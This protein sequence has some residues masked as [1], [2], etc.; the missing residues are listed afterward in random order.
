MI[1]FDDEIPNKYQTEWQRLDLEVKDAGKSLLHNDLGF[2]K[3]NKNI[4]KSNIPVMKELS[5]NPVSIK[6]SVI[7]D[8]DDSFIPPRNNFLF[9]GQKDHFWFDQTKENKVIDNN[10]NVNTDELQGLDPLNQKSKENLNYLNSLIETVSILEKKAQGLLENINSIYEYKIVFDKI[11]GE[12]GWYY[13]L[14]VK[15]NKSQFK[16][17]SNIELID[18][19][20]SNLKL[21][22]ES[23]HFELLQQE[24]EEQKKD[25]EQVT[26]EDDSSDINPSDGDYLLY[27]D[28]NLYSVLKTEE[29]A[30]KAIYEQLVVNNIDL[31]KLL[32]LRKI[33]INF[34]VI[35]G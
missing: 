3:V 6:A 1:D 26:N 23:K 24:K 32:L 27:I 16:S 10:N 30:K 35:L 15:L 20:Y 31:S 11:F 17:E 18:N 13:Q 9:V 28:G 22:F 33:P 14:I 25:E 2:P 34:G 19:S 4:K 8:D 5:S 21:E 7:E 12:S 29:D